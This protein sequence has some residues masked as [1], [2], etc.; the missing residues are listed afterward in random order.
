MMGRRK[1][2]IAIVRPLFTEVFFLLYW[3]LSS[4]FTPSLFPIEALYTC[5]QNPILVSGSVVWGQRSEGERRRG[6]AACAPR[7]RAG[8]G[9]S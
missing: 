3:L 8:E 5:T 9:P 2:P 6:E 7:T 1:R 4:H